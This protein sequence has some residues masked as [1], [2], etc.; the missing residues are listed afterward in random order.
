MQLPNRKLEVELTTLS[1]N[2]HVEMSPGDVGHNDRYVV[3]LAARPVG[4]EGFQRPA[5]LPASLPS[6]AGHHQ[7]DGQ[8]PATRPVGS[9]RLQGAGAERGRP[10]EP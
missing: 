2:Y 9:E 7:G 10:P 5:G 1:S 6:C 4:S 3:Q 8:E